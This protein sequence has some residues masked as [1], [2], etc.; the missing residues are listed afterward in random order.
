VGYCRNGVSQTDKNKAA[1]SGLFYC[2]IFL[3]KGVD[4][5]HKIGLEVNKRKHG[6]RLFFVGSSLYSVAKVTFSR[7]IERFDMEPLRA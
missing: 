5:Y 2:S 6:L 7:L 1:G 4:G 3:L